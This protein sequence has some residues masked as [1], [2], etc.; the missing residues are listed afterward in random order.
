MIEVLIVDDHTLVRKGLA[1]LLEG[2]PD[3]RVVDQ[4]ADGEEAVE[5]ARLYR[6]DIVLLDIHMPG[7]D[8]IEAARRIAQAYPEVNVI[9]LTMYGDEGHLFEAIKAG[10][11]GYVLKSA[12]PEQLLATIRTVYRGE[13]W[14]E[15]AMARKMLEEFR[16]LSQPKPRS[17]VVHLTP[18]EREILELLAQGASNAEIAKRLGIAE[19]TVRNRL[20][21]IFSKLHVNNRTQA[22]LKAREAGWVEG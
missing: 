2:E 19:K 4:A 3:I 12:H 14:L 15:P 21:L 11:K 22:A 10:A 18:R 1:Q 13:A 6:P 7:T 17:D 20:S 16:Q 9:M 5:K 8:G